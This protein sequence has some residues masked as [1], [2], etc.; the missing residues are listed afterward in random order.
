MILKLSYVLVIILA[1]FF[2]W[3]ALGV[4]VVAVIFLVY[5]YYASSKK[6]KKLLSHFKDEIVEHFDNLIGDGSYHY[7]Y[8][9]ENSLYFLNP[10][11]SKLF[12]S[13]LKAV[14]GL[15]VVFV[16]SYFFRYDEGVLLYSIISILV[17]I[18]SFN[19]SLKFTKPATAYQIRNTSTFSEKERLGL[20]EYP[21]FFYNGE[22][23]RIKKKGNDEWMANAKALLKTLKDDNIL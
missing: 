21:E 23:Q 11:S 2:P 14:S 10:A 22:W 8:I 13:V 7:K 18:Y 5:T 17:I 15:L 20:E 3:I 6:T 19:F 12:A 16:I 9:S 1:Y 4:I